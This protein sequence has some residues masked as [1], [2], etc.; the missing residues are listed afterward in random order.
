MKCCWTMRFESRHQIFKKIARATRQFHNIAYTCATRFQQ[1]ISLLLSESNFSQSFSTSAIYPSTLE[2]ITWE[3]LEAVKIYL[4]RSEHISVETPCF[5]TSSLKY[6]GFTF[7]TS[8]QMAL[9]HTKDENCEPKFAYIEKIL[10]IDSQWLAI[11]YPTDSC[12]YFHFAAYLLFT[13]STVP[14]VVPVSDQSLEPILVH[15][16]RCSQC[17]VPC[18]WFSS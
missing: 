17:V 9:V 2:C 3:E 7:S 14:F 18:G 8:Q 6:N 10:S 16:I 5:I 1:R 12:Y 11:C 4:D 13:R 15:T